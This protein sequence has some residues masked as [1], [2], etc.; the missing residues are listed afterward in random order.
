[1]EGEPRTI[2][3]RPFNAYGPY[4]SSKAVIPELILKC[5]RGVP[6]EC[7]AGERLSV[8]ATV[9]QGSQNFDALEQEAPNAVGHGRANAVCTGEG[10]VQE[11]PIRI[12][13]QGRETFVAGPATASGLAITTDRG[14]KT[15]VRQWQPAAG[16]TLQ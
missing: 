12:T 6:I 8:E 15:D 10:D 16:V 13:A 9:S 14:Q 4:Q 5:L 1:M 3:L 2:I 7:T 11:V